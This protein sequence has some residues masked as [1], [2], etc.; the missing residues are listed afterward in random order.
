MVRRISPIAIRAARSIQFSA[1]DGIALA[2]MSIDVRA[3][4]PTTI[5]NLLQLITAPRFDPRAPPSHH[6]ST[7]SASTRAG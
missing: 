3:T 5:A 6:T 1:I 4:F 2:A 7:M